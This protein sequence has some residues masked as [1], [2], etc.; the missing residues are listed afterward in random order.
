[1]AKIVSQSGE[2]PGNLINL[3]SRVFN[4]AKTKDCLLAG[5][6]TAPIGGTGL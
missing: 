4:E 5:A 1:M 2:I 3:A 6:A